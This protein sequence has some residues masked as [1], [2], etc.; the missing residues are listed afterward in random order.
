MGRQ[1]GRGL[2]GE[3]LNRRSL[4]GAL[5]TLVAT[6]PALGRK[7]NATIRYLTTV[8]DDRHATELLVEPDGVARL[9]IGSNRDQRAR[10]VGRFEAMLPGELLR[11]LQGAVADP[12]FAAAP[13]QTRLVPD[14]GYRSI[15]VRRTSAENVGKLIGEQ[16]APAPAFLVAEA[17]IADAIAHVARAPVHALALRL[18]PPRAVQPVGMPLS[19]ELHLA[20][21]GLHPMRLATP[22]LW[23]RGATSATLGALRADVAPASARPADQKFVALTVVAFKGADVPLSGDTFVLARNGRAR[24]RFELPIDWDRGRWTLEVDFEFSATTAEGAPLFTAALFTDPVALDVVR[25]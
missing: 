6:Q 11:R 25:G 19:L 15:E 3:E 14:E 22:A 24:L 12:A 20:N 2:E 10:P 9:S 4:I 16:L 7:M 13:A 23:S 8:A 17:A 5:V 18:T 1:V 21:V